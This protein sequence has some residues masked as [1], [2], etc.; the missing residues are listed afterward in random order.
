[1]NPFIVTPVSHKTGDDSYRTMLQQ[2][3]IFPILP[4]IS[5]TYSF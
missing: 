1:M 4:N 5:Y 2:V 3:T